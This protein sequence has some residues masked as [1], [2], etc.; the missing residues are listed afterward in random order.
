MY[1]LMK[2]KIQRKNKHTITQIFKLF[3]KY[4][5]LQDG[6]RGNMETLVLIL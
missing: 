4:A 6:I 3:N 5:R 2:S 1:V